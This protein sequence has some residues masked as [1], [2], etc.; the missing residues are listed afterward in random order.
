M[1]ED[2]FDDGDEPDDLYEF[3]LEVVTYKNAVVLV[4]PGVISLAMTIDAARKTAALLLEAAKAA[5]AAG[6]PNG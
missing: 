6:K 1:A 4:G 3:P 2:D 5:E